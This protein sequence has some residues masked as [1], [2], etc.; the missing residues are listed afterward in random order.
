MHLQYVVALYIHRIRGC[1]HYKLHVAFVVR[2]GISFYVLLFVRQLI[3]LVRNAG[4]IQC[5]R[6][7]L[8]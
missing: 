3:V 5:R 7:F 2:L 4:C 6:Q 1:R 8:L